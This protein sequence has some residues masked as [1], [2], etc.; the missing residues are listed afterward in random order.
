MTSTRRARH[1][2]RRFVGA[3]RPG[4]PRAA[5]V[6]WVQAT[7]TSEE[8]ALWARMPSHDRRHSIDVARRVEGALIGTEHSGDSRWLAAAL[9]HDVGKL[10][11]GLGVFGRVGATLAGGAAGHDM[12]EVWS[13]KR[14]ITRRVGLYLRHPELGATRIRTAGGRE[15]VARWAAVH[16]DAPDDDNGA[17]GFALPSAV[18]IALRDADDD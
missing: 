18:V 10:D 17:D 16:H 13:E 11:A 3:L 9:L 12:A 1:L 4:P 14:G 6:T 15:E 5:D 2:V 8:F 7:L